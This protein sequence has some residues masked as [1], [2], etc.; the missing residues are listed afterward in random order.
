MAVKN[1]KF[2]S[3]VKKSAK[4]YGSIVLSSTMPSLSETIVSSKIAMDEYTS[5]VNTSR[6]QMRSRK[7]RLT[8]IVYNN[9]KEILENAKEEL[10]S[11]DFFRQDGINTFIDM[12]DDEQQSP[13]QNSNIANN[14]DYVKIMS[15]T[16]A[17]MSSAEYT[18][19]VM[20]TGNTQNMVLQTKHHLEMM[21]G[22][23]N[24][25]DIGMSIAQF[26]NSTVSRAIE[27][28]YRYYDESLTELREIKES[29][30]KISD[31]YNDS[32]SIKSSAYD[33]ISGGVGGINFGE[34]K[35]LIKENFSNTIGRSLGDMYKV[36]KDNPIGALLTALGD[37]VLPKNLKNKAQSIDKGISATFSSFLLKMSELKKSDKAYNR[38]FG[39]LFGLPD[40]VNNGKINLTKY[41]EMDYAVMERQRNK[42]VIEVIPTY[43]NEIVKT[44]TGKDMFYNYDMG[45]FQNKSAARKRISED[46]D[47]V[48]TGKYSSTK[49]SFNKRFE[50]I[51]D[52]IDSN[53][54]RQLDDD[55]NK[56]L[57]FLSNTGIVFNPQEHTYTKLHA[58]GLRLSGGEDNF[59]IIVQTYKKLSTKERN[60]LRHEQMVSNSVFKEY[61]YRRN[62]E[63]QDSGESI[64]FNGFDDE[65]STKGNGAANNSSS[66]NNPNNNGP[67]GPNPNN[68]PDAPAFILMPD[69]SKY[70]VGSGTNNQ[71]SQRVRNLNEVLDRISRSSNSTSS[72]SG[73][74]ATSSSSYD[75]STRWGRF[76]NGARTAYDKTR[77]GINSILDEADYAMDRVG[78]ATGSDNGN[79]R[80]NDIFGIIG[81]LLKVGKDVGGDIIGGAKGQLPK[82]VVDAMEKYLPDSLK[83]AAKGAVVGLMA[84]HPVL[85]GAIGAGFGLLQANED[86]HKFLWGDPNGDRKGLLGGV[87]DLFK[88]NVFDPLK[89]VLLKFLSPVI[90]TVFDAS[91]SKGREIFGLGKESNDGSK[92]KKDRAKDFIYELFGWKSPSENQSASNRNSQS[93]TVSEN[94]LK[95]FKIDFQRFGRS[96]S[97]TPNNSSTNKKDDSDSP[98]MNKIKD[99][100][101]SKFNGLG[102]V[103]KN[104][105]IST[106]FGLGPLPGILFSMVFEKKDKKNKTKSKISKEDADQIN[107]INKAETNDDYVEQSIL[108]S[109]GIKGVGKLKGAAGGAIA[110]SLLGMNPLIGGAVGL[111]LSRKRQVK[112][113]KSKNKSGDVKEQVNDINEAENNSTNEQKAEQSFLDRMG[114]T[115]V[116]RLKGAAGGAVAAS[117]LGI[118][119]VIGGALGLF[120]TKKREVTVK[121]KNKSG[122]TQEQVNEIN[123]AEANSN[124]QKK[125]EESFLDRMG[126][127]GV[128]RLK[129]AAGGAI[130]ASLLGLNPILGG[131]IG[132]FLTKKRPTSSGNKDDSEGGI[133]NFLK[134]GAGKI[135]SGVKGV[136]SFIGSA[137]K[138]L[139]GKFASDSDSGK[140]NDKRARSTSMDI[141]KDI[142]TIQNKG[143][144]SYVENLESDMK[145]VDT[146]SELQDTA[147]RASIVSSIA[148][149]GGG[150]GSADKK[151]KEIKYKSWMEALGSMLG[152]GGDGDGAGGNGIF[153]SFMGTGLFSVLKSAGKKA[154]N[155]GKKG[156]NFAKNNGMLTYSGALAG[157]GL[158]QATIGAAMDA[159]NEAKTGGDVTNAV[160]ENV[161]GGGWKILKA[162]TINPKATSTFFK[163]LFNMV[164]TIAGKLATKFPKA[165]KLIKKILP[166]LSSVVSNIATKIAKKA[167]QKVGELAAKAA[168]ET[169]NPA[170][171]VVLVAE[172]LIEATWG[173]NTAAEILQ[174]SGKPTTGMCFACA[175]ANV[176]SQFCLGIIPAKPIA[177]LLYKAAGEEA[178]KELDDMQTKQY[179]EWQE[180]RNRTGSDITQDQYN[181]ATNK[182]WFQFYRGKG[183]DDYEREAAAN[184]GMT[185]VDNTTTNN[186]VMTTSDGGGRGGYT[187]RGVGEEVIN[188]MKSQDIFKNMFGNYTKVISSTQTSGNDK[189]IW[190]KATDKIKS[191]GSKA[192]N[193]ISNSK[194][195]QMV[196][197]AWAGIKSVGSKIK[198]IFTG[199]RG[200]D[201]DYYNQTDPRWSNM[202]FGMYNGARDTVGAGGCGPTAM[203][204][205]LQ[206]LTGGTISPKDLAEIALNGGYK[207]DD[208]GTDP[209]FFT[210]I[211]SAFGLNFGIENGVSKNAVANLANGIP[212]IF[213]GRDTDGKSPFGKNTHYVVGTGMDRNG[214]VSIL[215]PK[216]RH[217]NRSFNIRDI[218]NSTLQSIGTSL[219]GGRGKGF[220]NMI[221]GRGSGD[222][223]EII[224]RRVVP[225]STGVSSNY[226]NRTS[227]T[228]GASTNHKGV[229]YS[230][231]SGSSIN[232]YA[233]GT[234][235]AATYDSY[236][237]NYVVIDHGNGKQTVYCHASELMTQ[238]GQSV[239]GGQ[240]IAKVGSTG[241]S[242]GPHLHFSYKKNGSHVNP[243]EIVNDIPIDGTTTGESSGAKNPYT[244]ATEAVSGGSNS[245]GESA[246]EFKRTGKIVDFFNDLD[247]GFNSMIPK[248]FSEVDEKYTEAFGGGSSSSSGSS[249]DGSGGTSGSGTDN[250]GGTSTG[251]YNNVYTGSGVVKINSENS[252]NKQKVYSILKNAGFSEYGI[253]ALMANIKGESK[254]GTFDPTSYN[255]KGEDSHGLMQWN[256]KAGRWSPVVKWCKDNGYD[257]NTIEGQLA[258]LLSTAE[259]SSGGVE[260]NQS[261]SNCVINGTSLYSM[262]KNASSYDDATKALEHLVR[263]YELPADIPGAIKTRTGYLDQFLSESGGRG[264]IPKALLNKIKNGVKNA[265]PN[266]RI[267]NAR[268]TSPNVPLSQINT[269]VSEKHN[270]NVANEIRE[271]EKELKYQ[272]TE[273]SV[274]DSNGAILKVLNVIAD[275]LSRIEV[276]NSK[277]AEQNH[278]NLVFAQGGNDFGGGGAISNKNAMIQSIITGK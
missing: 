239:E 254:N 258:M 107:D 83:G 215:D 137:S 262:L 278:N 266:I 72:T 51:S 236:N 163:G 62:Y 172:L 36:F 274:S 114:I 185:Y 128:G 272:N 21:K 64:L 117:L 112:N 109:M 145:Q 63:V 132:L 30:N 200:S 6:S 231:P 220:R 187:G 17:S 206:K 192:W 122:G 204:T 201:P 227:P 152:L 244:A 65:P 182:R 43:L 151:N 1:R 269:L 188:S 113:K 160:V 268:G 22:L 219:S 115:G 24:L 235:S 5:F 97:G 42:A 196:K 94:N 147:T 11:G 126:I 81:S 144:S 32:K 179:T 86:V 59:K 135:I 103:A 48:I 10:T 92:G 20:I 217:N 82:S 275:T 246:G 167:P 133:L 84:K 276:Y 29:I 146:A 41:K 53:K 44:M 89:G 270:N 173:W 116:G 241:I 238:K 79:Y 19:D 50:S 230:A 88:K 198:N 15:G 33:K 224:R 247:T 251:E 85:G 105:A 139:F 49:E 102:R 166:K 240:C 194:L 120:L 180:F 2:L 75:T 78:D 216:N 252:A 159:Y 225:D 259:T 156:F 28:T 223:L 209:S 138:K 74:R 202:A 243:A 234:V 106:A 260:C 150:L 56:F 45:K 67:Y 134:S 127:K 130:A 55:T 69:G 177:E 68:G 277:M 229:D 57:I 108:D 256:E 136:G 203:A 157:A 221:F 273:N 211:G 208:G 34:Y 47:N 16:H 3:N 148:G 237:G 87:K 170:G 90:D 61:I 155:L 98:F 18:A 197:N 165:A 222:A 99:M 183:L 212:T 95:G 100:F 73:S 77:N 168:A 38:F 213:M 189:S 207:Y 184:N 58:M 101:G 119:P 264:S 161:G 104:A 40:Y 242:T 178:N 52:V 162:H 171:W 71:S 253:A 174:I 265:T 7:T 125:A 154:L 31:K 35:K 118:N 70:F 93:S 186:V 27:E 175:I 199:G 169:T 13:S 263:D 158:G 111:F 249:N 181:K 54:M 25:Q 96:G 233:A 124:N 141:Q 226:G 110:A 26:N 210:D 143:T 8:N 218:A 23:K 46:F 66:T 191:L 131:A 9:S 164:K 60:T 123:N 149:T 4:Y 193:K 142:D 195:G 271:I 245:S 39:N 255:P 250:S 153:N 140:T 228:T 257:P 205:V 37:N 76:K 261:L 232:A 91:M 176:I 214:N 248:W 14:S 267:S 121:S 129:G 80:Q 12:A 190:T